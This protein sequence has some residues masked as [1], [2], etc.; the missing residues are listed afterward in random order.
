MMIDMK[1]IHVQVMPIFGNVRLGRRG[2]LD[3][4]LRVSPV[5]LQILKNLWHPFNMQGIVVLAGRIRCSFQG[6][7]PGPRIFNSLVHL[8]ERQLSLLYVKGIMGFQAL[9]REEPEREAL[10]LVGADSEDDRAGITG[11]SRLSVDPRTA[12]RP[13]RRGFDSHGRAAQ[14]LDRILCPW[15][16]QREEQS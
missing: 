14:R 8:L 10:R 16:C 6:L 12:T 7:F 2:T 13:T 3:D 9:C 15:S 11:G 4:H 5:R 1:P